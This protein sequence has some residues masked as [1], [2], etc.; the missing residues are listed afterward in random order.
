MYFLNESTLDIDTMYT[1][2]VLLCNAI[3]DRQVREMSVLSRMDIIKQI[4][5]YDFDTDPVDFKESLDYA[6]SQIHG[7]YLSSR[8]LSSV[9]KLKTFKVHNIN[10]GFALSKMKGADGFCEIVAVH[11]ASQYRGL[12]VYLLPTAVELG[13]RYL[14]C[15]GDFLAPKLYAGYGFEVYD[16]IENVKMRNGKTSD[17]HRMKL[18]GFPAPRK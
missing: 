13:G 7:E 4:K 15:F 18:K 10:A 3:M 8:S 1:D 16:T 12:G 9:Q 2:Y 17:L 6:C 11:N 14:E 5:N